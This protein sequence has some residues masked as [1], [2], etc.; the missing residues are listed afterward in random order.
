LATNRFCTL[1]TCSADGLPWASPLLYG[2]DSALQIYWSSAISARH[3]EYIAYNHGRSAVTI[4]DS[5]AQPGNI[6]GLFLFGHTSL[7]SDTEVGQAMEYLFAR[8]P[9]RPDRTARDY[10]GE[11][12]RRFYQFQP[13]EIWITGTRVTVGKQPVDTKVQL[14]RDCLR[15]YLSR[16]SASTTSNI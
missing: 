4:Y 2:Y 12:P 14:D 9:S 1:A 8:M 5:H 6:N 16:F 15:Q 13:T 10:L 11:S 7:V 3:S